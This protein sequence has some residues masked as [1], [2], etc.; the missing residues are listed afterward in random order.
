MTAVAVHLDLCEERELDAVARA[1]EFPDFCVTARFL[2]AKLIAGKPEDLESAIPLFQS[3]LTRTTPH[4]IADPRGA[5][6]CLFPNSAGQ[7]AI[8]NLVDIL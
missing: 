7:S 6:F 1:T 3:R 4:R 8:H 2:R 5:H